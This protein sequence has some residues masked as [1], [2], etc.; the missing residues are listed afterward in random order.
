MY[1]QRQVDFQGVVLWGTVSNITNVRIYNKRDNL[2]A[3]CIM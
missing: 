1:E 3:L 2:S